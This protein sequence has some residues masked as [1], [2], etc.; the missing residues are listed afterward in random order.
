MVTEKK[1][2]KK[3]K[4]KTLKTKN[5]ILPRA[6]AVKSQNMSHYNSKVYTYPALQ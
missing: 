1:K 5:Y 3:N 6:D 2:K 4:K